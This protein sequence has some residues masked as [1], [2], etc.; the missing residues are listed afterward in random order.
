M[1]FSGGFNGFL[2]DLACAVESTVYTLTHPEIWD[3]DTSNAS[4]LKAKDKPMENVA[5]NLKEL[6]GEE[7]SVILIEKSID[8]KFWEES[9]KVNSRK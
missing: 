2:V 9:E 5:S 6:T 3:T 7:E 1:L 4:S 8:S